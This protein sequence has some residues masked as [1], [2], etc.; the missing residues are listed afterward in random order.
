C[1]QLARWRADGAEDLWVAVN[2]SARQLGGEALVAD[3]DAA[4][5]HFGVPPSALRVEITESLLIENVEQ[6]TATLRLLRALGVQVVVDDFGTGFSSLS[7]LSRFPVDV[8]K[9]DKSLMAGLGRDERD[10]AIV[11]A[12]VGLAH[13]LGLEAIGEGVEDEHQFAAL[14]ALGCDQAQ[15]FLF[16]RPKAGSEVTPADRSA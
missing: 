16:G 10:T 15:G 8:L 13:T 12:V 7:Y 11:T 2:L 1:S 5:R 6:A 4:V 9:I 14:R 3:I